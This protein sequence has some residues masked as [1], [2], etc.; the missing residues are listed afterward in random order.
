MRPD[1]GTAHPSRSPGPSKTQY[2]E[3]ER[4]A[5]SAGFLD[6]QSGCKGR[7]SL[8]CVVNPCNPTGDFM[9]LQEMKNWI[10]ALGDR[11][12]HGHMRGTTVLVDESM[13]MW[14]GAAWMEAS[15]ASQHDWLAAMA[16]RGVLVFILHSWTKLWCCP[17][18]RLGSCVCPT[19]DLAERVRSRQVPWS[20]NSP[21]LAFLSAAIR[22]EGFLARTWELTPQWNRSAR[23][24]MHK[25]FPGWEV[26]GP[27]WASWLWV[28]TGDGATLKAALLLAREA[29]LPIRS[30]V[31]GYDHPTCFRMAVRAPEIILA[32]VAALKGC[33]LRGSHP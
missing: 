14:L 9:P 16:A 22:D 17:G 18:L 6:L 31:A 5:H 24:A 1:L 8:V 11:A 3:Y 32:L 13:L 29:G 23:E 28:D 4:S 25:A 15:L 33:T 12:P 10:E 19:L 7:A 27:S 2:K 20:I 30:G 21:A 26:H